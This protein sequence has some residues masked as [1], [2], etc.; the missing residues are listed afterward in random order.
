MGNPLGPLFETDADPSKGQQ[1]LET[2]KASTAT[3]MILAQNTMLEA[4]ATQRSAQAHWDA[5]KAVKDHQTAIS[6]LAGNIPG[7]SMPIRAELIPSLAELDTTVASV[8]RRLADQLTPSFE[9]SGEAA[10]TFGQTVTNAFLRAT[11]ASK[12]AV[13]MES[14][15]LAATI[16]SR[17]VAAGIEAVWETAKGIASLAEWDFR[18]AALHFMSA[19]EY[20]IIAGTRGH[21]AGGGY[22]GREPHYLGSRGEEIGRGG[23]R[24]APTGGGTTVNVH[25][26]G[27]FLNTPG[28]QAKL[29]DM[30]ADYVLNKDGFL[31][32][33]HV[34]DSTLMRDS[35]NS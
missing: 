21:G 22:G 3:Q 28:T 8:S 4:A 2:L 25:I 27:D 32:A 1:A 9:K 6:A 26:Y 7:L 20:G 31:P 19:A 10:T 12:G 14:A 11:D 29:G 15:R 23:S 17:R 24:T 33:S 35:L 30:L 16:G 34:K 13:V 5:A 18:G